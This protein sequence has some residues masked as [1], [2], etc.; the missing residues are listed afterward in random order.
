MSEKQYWVK[1]ELKWENVVI[2]ESM[3][4]AIKNIKRTMEHEH[5]LDLYDDE[6]ISIQL[7]DNKGG[8]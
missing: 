2:A 4:E 3:E 7:V 6:I 5:N 8:V 1:I